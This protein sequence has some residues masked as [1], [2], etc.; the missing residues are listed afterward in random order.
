[1]VLVFFYVFIIIITI[2]IYDYYCHF[3]INIIYFIPIG[4]EFAFVA[5]GI[6]EKS[7]LISKAL[8]KKLLTTVAL[9]MAL[10]PLLDDLGR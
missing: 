5:F 6:A 7:G 3:S 1:M 2:D 8:T 10:T 9:S 4:G